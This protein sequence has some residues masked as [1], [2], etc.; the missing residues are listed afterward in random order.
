MRVAARGALGRGKSTRTTR[1]PSRS[2]GPNQPSRF[3]TRLVVLAKRSA[4]KALNP[5]FMQD[6]TLGRARNPRNPDAF[7]AETRFSLH[8]GRRPGG[9]RNCTT[10][11]GEFGASRSAS[12]GL[13]VSERG[14]T[15]VF[16]APHTLTGY[17]RPCEE[18]RRLA[19]RGV[20]PR[21]RDRLRQGSADCLRLACSG[22]GRQRFDSCT[23]FG[24]VA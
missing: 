4:T 16:L 6:T 1:T 21:H 22:P 17:D 23:N 24:I 15:I 20:A 14:W 7:H 19:F 2:C 13:R 9:F 11:N 8:Q 18:C 3:S 5:R 12:A 10:G